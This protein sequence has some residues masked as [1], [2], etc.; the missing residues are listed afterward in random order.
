M[1]LGSLTRGEGAESV[2][3]HGGLEVVGGDAESGGG[4]QYLPL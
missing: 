2:V 3:S 4:A 1:S